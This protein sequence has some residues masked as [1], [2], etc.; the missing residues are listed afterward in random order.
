MRASGTDRDRWPSPRGR[1]LPACRRRRPSS[2]VNV[3]RDRALAACDRGTSAGP[4]VPLPADHVAFS[5]AA[6]CTAC[7]GF[8]A[9]TP[10]KF[11]FTTT[12]TSP[13]IPRT[14]DSSTLTRLAPTDGGRTTRPC[15]IPGT[16]TLWT[17]SK[18]PVASAGMS[19]RL[20]GV[21]STVHVLGGFRLRV[22]VEADVERPA[23]DE[24]AVAHAL[25]R[26]GA[27]R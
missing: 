14:D 11:F 9:T 23:T 20:T 8:S 6:A 21:P 5:F 3:S 24:L 16:R 13:G 15:S 10:T 19:S 18:R 17:N 25:R 7:H 27:R 1:H 12:F 2:T 26:I 22:R 4:A